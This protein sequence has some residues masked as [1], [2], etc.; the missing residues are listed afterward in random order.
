MITAKN[1]NSSD[2][3]TASH[4]ICRPWDE[5]LIL[6]AARMAYGDKLRD[7]EGTRRWIGARLADRDSAVILWGSTVVIVH[8][9]RRFYDPSFVRAKVVFFFSTDPSMGNLLNAFRSALL[10]A[11]THGATKLFFDDSTGRNI[12]P[13]AKRLGAGVEYV[14]YSLEL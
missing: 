13:L 10:W 3:F 6:R 4:R 8:L 2:N 1:T 12:A 14:A 9:Q 7:Y 11:G 5:G